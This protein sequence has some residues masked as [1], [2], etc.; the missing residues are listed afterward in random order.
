MDDLSQIL[1]DV[2][3]TA[4][5]YS[6]AA[7]A[8]GQPL[9]EGML[10][11]PQINGEHVLGHHGLQD[12]LNEKLSQKIVSASERAEDPSLAGI[13]G[14]GHVEKAVNTHSGTLEKRARA[15]FAGDSEKPE[16]EPL[17]HDDH[18]AFTEEIT[19]LANNPAALIDRLSAATSAMHAVAPQTAA[20]TQQTAARAIQFL[21]TKISSPDPE[22][23]GAPSEPSATERLH[24]DRYLSIV[25]DPTRALHQIH[26]GTLIPE[27]TETLGA[28]YPQLYGKMKQL[29]IAHMSPQMPYQTKVMVSQF[30]GEPLDSSLS[31]ERIASLQS[32]FIPAQEEQAPAGGRAPH[33]VP[34]K[35]TLAD[36]TSIDN[37]DD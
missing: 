15:I 22:P 12:L 19:N 10:G 13:A 1:A 29:M 11:D 18:K 5:S 37:R 35:L 26:E 17:S 7:E 25:E 6:P 16:G 4:G 24:F 21:A 31:P 23:L 14:L 8:L 20:S 32:T 28:V 33:R 2:P 3:D 36:R 9:H 34:S 30:M 27:T